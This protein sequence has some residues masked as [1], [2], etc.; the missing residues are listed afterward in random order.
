MCRAVG[1]MYARSPVL[2]TSTMSTGRVPEYALTSICWYS[3]TPLA[4]LTLALAMFASLK[5]CDSCSCVMVEVIPVG[6]RKGEPTMSV[7]NPLRRGMAHC[8][9]LAATR[10][11]VSES[12]MLLAPVIPSL[13]IVH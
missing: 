6:I 3:V 2:G 7:A 5:T 10:V 1:V 11:Q 4:P 12:V 8:H 9:P 13:Q